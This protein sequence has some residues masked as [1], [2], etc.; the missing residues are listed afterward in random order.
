MIWFRQSRLP[1]IALGLFGLVAAKSAD[2]SP[3][4]GLVGLWRFDEN[5]GVTAFD[6]SGHG[7]DGSLQGVVSLAAPQ[8]CLDPGETAV[9]AGRPLERGRRGPQ[10]CSRSFRLRCRSTGESVTR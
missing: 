3:L 2:A 4:D 7:H 8:F 6:S 5:R 10:S 1:A 9:L